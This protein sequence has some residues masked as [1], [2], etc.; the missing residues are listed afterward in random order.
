MSTND[1]S[2]RRDGHIRSKFPDPRRAERS[3]GPLA[4]MHK[5]SSAP[6]VL[7]DEPRRSNAPEARFVPRQ[8]GVIARRTGA[9]A[10][11]LRRT[12]MRSSWRHSHNRVPTTRLLNKATP[13]P[14]IP[15]SYCRPLTCPTSPGGAPRTHHHSPMKMARTNPQGSSIPA[16]Q[17]ARDAAPRLPR[18]PSRC[19]LMSRV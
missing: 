10:G 6:V 12:A 8:S 16:S 9:V 2:P 1:V 19:R 5:V 14:G 3:P 13:P 15:S 4:L 17:Y 11:R 7:P 18:R